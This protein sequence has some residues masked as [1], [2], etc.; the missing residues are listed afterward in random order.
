MRMCDNGM[1]KKKNLISIIRFNLKY[2]L[3][4]INSEIIKLVIYVIANSNQGLA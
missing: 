1:G 3:I 4:K 2:Y